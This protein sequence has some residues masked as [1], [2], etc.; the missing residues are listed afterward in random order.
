[1]INIAKML[2]YLKGGGSLV[3]L[4]VDGYHIF[5]LHLSF[6]GEVYGAFAA[7][8]REKD[9]TSIPLDFPANCCVQ[10]LAQERA[11]NNVGDYWQNSGTHLELGF[12]LWKV[13]A[14]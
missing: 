4:N 5:Y 12:I 10:V 9:K 8:G 13:K 7:M 2:N 1:M 11:G 6:S 14:F 3:G